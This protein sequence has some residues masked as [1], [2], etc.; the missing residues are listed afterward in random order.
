MKAYWNELIGPDDEVST[1]TTTTTVSDGGQY[2]NIFVKVHGVW[3]AYR[4]F[5][6]FDSKNDKY[7]CLN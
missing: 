3:R 5:I 1:P 2:E 4:S 6:I 7:P